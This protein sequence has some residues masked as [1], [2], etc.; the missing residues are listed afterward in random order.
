[1]WTSRSSHSGQRR[2]HKITKKMCFKVE[3]LSQRK[4]PLLCPWSAGS[5]PVLLCHTRE[6]AIPR[7]RNPVFYSRLRKSKRP[8]HLEALSTSSFVPFARL[9]HVGGSSLLL[10][11]GEPG[12]HRV[13]LTPPS[14]TGRASSELHRHHWL[15]SVKMGLREGSQAREPQPPP[16]NALYFSLFLARSLDHCRNYLA[17]VWKRVHQ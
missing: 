9:G 1:M 2:Q 4:P 11:V 13:P 14:V 16:S 12:A 5:H 8:E 3:S 7:K 6:K 15:P 17:K 10:W